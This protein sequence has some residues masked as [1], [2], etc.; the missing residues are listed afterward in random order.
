MLTGGDDQHA[1]QIPEKVIKRHRMIDRLCCHIV[2]PVL[3]VSSLLLL[4]LFPAV[5]QFG[6]RIQTISWAL[7]KTP[8]P[9]FVFVFSRV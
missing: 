3:F 5:F 8:S 4:L 2:T 9:V 1:E 6:S 7:Q